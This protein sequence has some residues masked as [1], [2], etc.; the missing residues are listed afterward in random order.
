M[1]KLFKVCEFLRQSL[2]SRSA[3][4]EIPL[5]FKQTAPRRLFGMS[6]TSPWGG[7]CSFTLAI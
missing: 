4:R 5:R 7:F 1:I 3:E 2:K 6:K